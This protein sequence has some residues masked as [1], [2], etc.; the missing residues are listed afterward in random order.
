MDSTQTQTQT[1]TTTATATTSP[2]HD[3][4]A[5]DRAPSQ[6]PAEMGV[7]V[8]ALVAAIGFAVA[9][10]ATPDG[11]VGFGERL[12]LGYGGMVALMAALRVGVAI[13]GLIGALGC[14][15]LVWKDPPNTHYGTSV[16]LVVTAMASLCLATWSHFGSATRRQL[17]GRDR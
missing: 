1:Q 3:G 8:A 4:A 11:A 16:P 14:A 10:A 15:A 12:A 13:P 9:A 17:R 7:R 5:S 6:R 2:A